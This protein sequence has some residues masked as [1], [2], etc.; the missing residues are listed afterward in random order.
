MRMN[1]TGRRFG[2]LT[3]VR[4]APRD[5]RY[6][7]SMW[8]CRCDCG[9]ELVARGSKLRTGKKKSCST[10][11]AKAWINEVA[12]EELKIWHQMKMRCYNK[13]DPSYRLYGKRG[14][15]MC[16]QWK[17]SFQQ[18]LSDVGPRPSAKHSLDR[19]PN[20][21]G[22]YEPENCRWATNKEQMRN[23]SKT[24]F[25]EYEGKRVPLIELS[26]KLGLRRQMVV[27]RLNRGWLLE[28]A[29]LQPPGK[30][31]LGSG[32]LADPVATI[33]WLYDCFDPPKDK[34]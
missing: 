6:A 26:E 3:A 31:L 29:L 23:T 8:L 17:N 20:N 15:K 12:A 16:S 7:D 18:F 21:D 1:L 10:C 33:K 4:P 25:V 9:A 11:F 30:H 22:N 34:Q 27:R 24:I 2:N 14:I 5:K 19:Y 28:D 32:K 13:R